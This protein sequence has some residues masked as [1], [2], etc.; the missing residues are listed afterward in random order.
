[1]RPGDACAVVSGAREYPDA[2]EWLFENLVL[3]TNTGEQKKIKVFPN[4]STDFLYLDSPSAYFSFEIYSLTGVKMLYGQSKNQQ[5]DI[6]SL[7]GG[8]YLLQIL[9]PEGHAVNVRF[10]K[11]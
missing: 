2:Y 10:I 3:K 4:P 1:M 11:L 9:D 8:M 6:S 5:I 7:P